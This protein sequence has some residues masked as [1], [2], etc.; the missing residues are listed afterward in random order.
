MVSKG[1][2]EYAAIKLILFWILLL[3]WGVAAAKIIYG[4]L[5]R[6]T[7]M[8]ADGI[9]SFADGA[10][11]IICLVGIYLAS[12]PTDS[13]HPY[14]HKKYETFFSLGI[15]ILLF[16]AAFNL[17]REGISRLFHP[18]LPDIDTGS[19]LVMLATMIVNV[20]VMR[21]E[22]KKGKELQSDLLVS[23]SLHTRADL[24]T[25]LSVVITLVAVKL[26]YTFIDP[27]ATLLIAAFITFA[28]FEIMREGARV[29]CDSAPIDDIKRITDIIMSVEG[30]QACHKIRSRGRPDDI[31]LDLHVQVK[32]NMHIDRA[33]RISYAIEAKLKEAIPEISDVVV[34]MEPKE[35]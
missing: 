33:H 20:A 19:F 8:T 27:V 7:S 21:Y 13:D 10:S 5:S 9:H 17:G 24:L 1:A 30:V 3:N 32:P 22:Y 14:G 16:L 31:Y 4:L 12:Q 35:E 11:N 18:V 6:C 34:H 15:A 2:K 23:D 26:G 25:S 28:G 29:L